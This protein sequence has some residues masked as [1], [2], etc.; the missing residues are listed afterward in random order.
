MNLPSVKH[1]MDVLSIDR[2]TAKKVRAIM[3]GSPRTKHG[4]CGTCET[5]QELVAIRR[6]TQ[7]YI[8]PDC[9]KKHA[10]RSMYQYESQGGET[11]LER[12]DVV[13]GNCGVE[14]IPEG[15]NSRSPA[16]YYSNTGDS[17]GMTVMRI[18]NAFKLG[19]W[20]DIVERGDYD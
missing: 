10:T 1:M 7:E 17:Y 9:A 8:C 18:N 14:Y 16:I 11:R 12:I 20:G 5:E 4:T 15:R 3:E 13:L 6:D 2:T 19:A